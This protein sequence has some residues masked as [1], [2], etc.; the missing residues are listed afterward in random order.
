MLIPTRAE[1]MS[2]PENAESSPVGHFSVL[3]DPRDALRCRHR[4]LDMVVIA[5]A[6]TL[7]GADGWVDI[8]QF[9]RAKEAWFRRFLDLPNGIPSH[10]TFGRVFSLLAPDAFEACFRAW[11]ASL[12]TV[13]PGGRAS[14]STARRCAVRMIGA[15]R[16]RR[17]SWSARGRPPTG[18]S[19]GR[20]PPRPHPTRSPRSRRCWNC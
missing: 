18:W 4:L 19:S 17:C 15:R 16:W 8:A 1:T 20:S 9:G 12:R 2:A 7:G 3:E 14:P 6:G 13:I 10:D 11:V 5:I